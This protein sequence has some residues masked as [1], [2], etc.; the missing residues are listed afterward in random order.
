MEIEDD[1]E[2]KEPKTNQDILN[3]KY[4]QAAN[5]LLIPCASALQLQGFMDEYFEIDHRKKYMA[6]MV[7]KRVLMRKINSRFNFSR[8]LNKNDVTVQN[9]LYDENYATAVLQQA[10]RMKLENTANYMKDQD[11][12]TF[13]ND[14]GPLKLKRSI[15]P[16]QKF[17]SPT[18]IQQNQSPIR[19]YTPTSRISW[20]ETVPDYQ[21]PITRPRSATVLNQR[22]SLIRPASASAIGRSIVTSP[23]STG[24]RKLEKTRVHS[25]PATRQNELPQTENAISDKSM[26]KKD[27]MR[28]LVKK[29][30]RE[31]GLP[32][33]IFE[34]KQ[35]SS[36]TLKE[37]GK[38]LFL[39]KS[40][41]APDIYS[42]QKKKGINWKRKM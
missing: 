6:G 24:G 38:I 15:S 32:V 13:S 30:G 17:N 21:Y 9:Q 8:S 11:T 20:Q 1:Q 29:V 42:D 3:E 31:Y 10:G 4:W 27:S 33:E 7:I 23:M 28:R 14:E 36:N 35:Y 25:A 22:E 37:K 16:D 5:Q 39:S 26:S 41:S 18:K 12:T 34:G 2:E 19:P 40:A